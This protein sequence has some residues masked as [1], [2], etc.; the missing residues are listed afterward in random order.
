MHNGITAIVTVI[1]AV[2]AV[3]IIAVLV[4]NSSNTA[5]VLTQGGTAFSN[6]LKAA[7]SPVTGSQNML[8]S[9]LQNPA[10]LPPPG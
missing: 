4:S 7:L 8:G 2:I 9:I 10:N 3:A 6:I 1:T 5:N